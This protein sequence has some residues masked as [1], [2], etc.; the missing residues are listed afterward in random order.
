MAVFSITPIGWLRRGYVYSHSPY[1]EFQ[2]FCP[3]RFA[4]F[5]VCNYQCRLASIGN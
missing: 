1:D 5:Y 4:L 2:G 3:A